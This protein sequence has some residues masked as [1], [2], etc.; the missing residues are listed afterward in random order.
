[1]S[2]CA[3]TRSESAIR[4]SGAS[5]ATRTVAK[6]TYR[7]YA[8]PLTGGASPRR[9]RA[10]HAL[11][12]AQSHCGA[13][14][15]R[16]RSMSSRM[17]SLR[18]PLQ[19]SSQR[20]QTSRRPMARRQ[21]KRQALLPLRIVTTSPPPRPRSMQGMQIQTT[22]EL[23][24]RTDLPLALRRLH[25]DLRLSQHLRR[26]HRRPLGGSRACRKSRFA[27]ESAGAVWSQ[28]LS[29]V[30]SYLRVSRP[31]WGAGAVIV[32]IEYIKAY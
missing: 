22:M 1:M 7:R 19:P 28:V 18:R 31:S 9:H 24:M 25:L 26:Q 3:R 23:L 4:R 2:R 15:P 13:P 27:C 32:V 21:A 20:Q 11:V 29:P 14:I 6:A 12:Q 5:R 8:S 30:C 16:W 17:P 10:Q